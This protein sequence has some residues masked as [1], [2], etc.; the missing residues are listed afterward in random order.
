MKN[1]KE[2]DN[3][4]K[5]KMSEALLYSIG[6]EHAAVISDETDTLLDEY[7]DIEV[8]ES[9]DT[10]FSDIIEKSE[11][12]EKKEQRLK[13]VSK[14]GKRAAIIF[15]VFGLV[16]TATIFSVDAFRV[17]FLNMIIE[18]E[19]KYSAIHFEETY[20]VDVAGNIPQN[21][22]NYYPAVLPEGYKFKSAV[23]LESIKN[24]VFENGD[25]KELHFSQMSISTDIQ[26]DTEN[27]EVS[28][29]KVNGMEG[30]ASVKEGYCILVWHD[31][32]HIFNL[33]GYV[34]KPLM[35]KIAESVRKK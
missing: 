33:L 18:V 27:A 30:I 26:I 3:V 31:D 24:I 11:K 20:A 25:S 21:W 35:I 19:E 6:D 2:N 15:V 17:K 13:K 28:N 7:S 29:I 1:S 32:N 8:P 16:T 34:E 5:D 23:D 12:N 22:D 9:L 4:L 10:W 14:F